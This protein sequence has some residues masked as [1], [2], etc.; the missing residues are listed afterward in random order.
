MNSLMR[1][2]MET[3]NYL[4]SYLQ[5]EEPATLFAAP[6]QQQLQQFEQDAAQAARFMEVQQVAF[7]QTTAPLVERIGQVNLLEIPKRELER[8]QQ[9]NL[10]L[11]KVQQRLQEGITLQNQELGKLTT[12]VAESR[13]SMQKTTEQ[14][15]QQKTAPD[16]RF[17]TLNEAISSH[18]RESR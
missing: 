12:Q 18:I 9:H 2:D 11:Q 10:R 1:I 15:R 16:P 8:L 7:E 5:G 17:V 3:A 6:A 4:T 14:L 13:L